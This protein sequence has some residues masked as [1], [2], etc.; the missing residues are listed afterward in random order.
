MTFREKFAKE[1]HPRLPGWTADDIHTADWCPSDLLYEPYKPKCP[2]DEYGN[3]DCDSC[4]DREIPGTTNNITKEEVKKMENNTA[5]T[6]EEMKA[7]IAALQEQIERQDQLKGL[8]EGAQMMK[9]MMDILTK[10]GFTQA[11]AF[12]FLMTIV[13]TNI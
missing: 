12:E 7:E 9:S 5:K 6:V 3:V 10:A 11:Q 8:E 1:G 4:W 2:K 13:R